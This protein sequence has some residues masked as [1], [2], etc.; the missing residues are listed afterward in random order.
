MRTLTG[1]STSFEPAKEKGSIL[2]YSVMAAA[3]AV[4]RET[5]GPCRV[6]EGGSAVS[7]RVWALARD[8]EQGVVA[9][10]LK[11]HGVGM[12]EVGLAGWLGVEEAQG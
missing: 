7:D 5:A 1:W 9:S 2:P 8:G 12:S 3:A 4:A 11:G 10:L 6:A